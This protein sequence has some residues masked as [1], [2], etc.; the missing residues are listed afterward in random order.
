MPKIKLHQ[1]TRE[2]ACPRPESKTFNDE[3]RGLMLGVLQSHFKVAGGRLVVKSK[4]VGFRSFHGTFGLILIYAAREHQSC[5]R[6]LLRSFQQHCG[7][8]RIGG[9]IRRTN[10]LLA[11]VAEMQHGQAFWLVFPARVLTSSF[12]RHPMRGGTRITRGVQHAH[13][14]CVGGGS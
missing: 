14:E 12:N 4:G 3:G 6:S 11:S 8:T 13:R 1:R 5:F 2:F 9:L 10:V 7:D